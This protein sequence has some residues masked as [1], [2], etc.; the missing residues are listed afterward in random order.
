MIYLTG[1][2]HGG[3]DIHKLTTKNF[4]EGKTLTKDDYVVVLGDF[5]FLWHEGDKTDSYWLEWLDEKPWTTLWIDGNHE[6]F[7]MIEALPQVPM[8]GN[9]V[10]KVTNSVFHLK[11]GI[12]YPIDGHK[13][14]CMG[15]GLSIDKHLR[16][17]GKSW[18]P[19]EI[20]NDEEWRTA[21][22]NLLDAG[23]EVDYVFAHTCPTDVLACHGIVP[24][25]GCKNKLIDPVSLKLQDIAHALEFKVWY[26]GHL[27]YDT[28]KMGRFVSIYNQVVKLGDVL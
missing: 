2:T 28:T 26:H 19:Q 13:I 6:N 8:F 25:L 10:G 22:S 4:P 20:P 12:V 3:M 17:I 14:F 15:G 16:Q 7:D 21:W 23:M 24:P 1:D 9:T 5:G 11:R 18:W 27:H